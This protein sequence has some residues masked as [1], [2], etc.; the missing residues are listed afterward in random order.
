MKGGQLSIHL[1]KN[2]LNPTSLAA[3]IKTALNERQ[4]IKSKI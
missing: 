4:Q 1:F 3:S 2:L